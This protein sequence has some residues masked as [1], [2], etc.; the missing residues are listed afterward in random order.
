MPANQAASRRRGTA[1]LLIRHKVANYRKWNRVFSDSR[2]M[3]KASGSKGGDLFRSAHE[4]RELVIV[5]RWKT[6]DDARQFAA[7][8]DFKE[9]MAR[10]GV[11]DMPDVYLL[12][13]MGTIAR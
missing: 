6:V 13:K 1:Y 3:R 8:D 10:A 5:L 12:E 4:P 9:A 11:S 2:Q 7:S